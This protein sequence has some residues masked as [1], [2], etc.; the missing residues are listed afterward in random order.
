M[1]EFKD[2]QGSQTSQKEEPS[3]TDQLK[4]FYSEKIDEGFQVKDRATAIELRK[5]GQDELKLGDGWN[6]HAK[7]ILNKVLEEKGLILADEPIKGRIGNLIISTPPPPEK[8]IEEQ[9]QQGALPKEETKIASLVPLDPSI[10]KANQ[11]TIKEAFRFIGQIYSYFG[12]IEGEVETKQEPMTREKFEEEAAK[13]AERVG[14]FCYRRNIQ[15]PWLIEVLSLI[16]TAVILFAIPL[17]KVLFS[18]TEDTKEDDEPRTDGKDVPE[19]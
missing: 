10:E 18:K 12:I 17:I 3:I 5:M 2:D 9:Q 1:N 11:E 14:T 6:A 4:E 16:G 7:K 13:Y 15:I 19:P 8:I